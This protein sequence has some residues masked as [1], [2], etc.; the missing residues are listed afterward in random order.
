MLISETPKMLKS[1][2]KQFDSELLKLYRAI[3]GSV[4]KS[5]IPL[6]IP[7]CA[8]RGCEMAWEAV[9]FEMFIAFPPK[10]LPF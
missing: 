1:L 4:K 9:V 3:D 5:A 6:G 8:E 2:G 10:K 7:K